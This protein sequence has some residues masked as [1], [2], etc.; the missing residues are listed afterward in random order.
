MLLK[1]SW[2]LLLSEFYLILL[3]R[4]NMNFT[5]TYSRI[6]V[7]FNR[8]LITVEIPMNPPC[9]KV[10]IVI[11]IIHQSTVQTCSKGMKRMDEIALVCDPSFILF[12]LL[13]NPD[14]ILSRGCKGIKNTNPGNSFFN[15]CKLSVRCHAITIKY[16]SVKKVHHCCS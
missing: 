2:N 6:L 4:N 13:V 8:L 7:S 12:Y 11:F 9:E 14:P 15:S 5:K 16:H 1:T 3:C 10:L